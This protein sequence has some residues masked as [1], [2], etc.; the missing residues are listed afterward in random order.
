MAT[1]S[2]EM[3][4]APPGITPESRVLVVMTGG[5]ICMEKSD[6]GLIPS[7][8]FLERCMAPRPEFNDGTEQDDID[9]RVEVDGSILAKSLRS[10]RTPLSS[11]GSRIRHVSPYVYDDA[12]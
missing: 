8:N 2:P 1:D 7:P 11:Y 5:T 10:L 12:I 6:H 9:V 3:E 4:R